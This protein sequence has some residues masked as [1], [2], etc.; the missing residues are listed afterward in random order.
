MCLEKYNP[1]PG[2][3]RV[4]LT[5]CCI[6]QKEARAHLPSSNTREGGPAVPLLLDHHG[7]TPS[8]RQLTADSVTTHKLPEQLCC[9]GEDGETESPLCNTGNPGSPG[10]APNK[11]QDPTAGHRELLALPSDLSLKESSFGPDVP[12]PGEH[13]K[14]CSDPRPGPTEGCWPPFPRPEDT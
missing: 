1:T 5:A 7:R 13:K 8:T 12:L 11:P 9:L 6:L 2:S 4:F 14:H 3:G 10:C